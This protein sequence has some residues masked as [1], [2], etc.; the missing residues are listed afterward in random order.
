MENRINRKNTLSDRE[1]GIR[2]IT[3]WTNRQFSGDTKKPLLSFITKMTET[4]E[5]IRRNIPEKE[6]TIQY[7][8]LLIP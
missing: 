1:T 6:K 7:G 3:E 8:L 2:H 5:S 4:A